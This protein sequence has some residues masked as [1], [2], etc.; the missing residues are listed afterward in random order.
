MKFESLPFD[1]HGDKMKLWF[2]DNMLYWI[3]VL[4]GYVCAKRNSCIPRETKSLYSRMAEA[5]LDQ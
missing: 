5:E 2:W 3:E 1:I 4:Q